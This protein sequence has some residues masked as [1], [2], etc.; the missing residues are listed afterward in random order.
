MLDARRLAIPTLLAT[1]AALAACGTPAPNASLEQ[2]RSSYAAAS[3]DPAVIRGANSEL[4]T[5]R[6]MLDNANSSYAAGD[7]AAEVTHRAYLASQQVQVAR[8]TA[9]ATDAVQHYREA[10]AQQA[11]TMADL[12]ARQTPK[13]L[14]MTLGSLLFQTGKAELAPGAQG[15]ID[16]LATFLRQN[17]GRSVEIQGYTDNTGSESANM[18]LSR[19]RADTV[20]AALIARGVGASRIET[21]GLGEAEPVADNSTPEGRQMNRRVEVVMANAPPTASGGS[22]PPISGS[23]P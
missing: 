23:K 1:A 8:E 4:Q 20:R 11:Q 12:K 5:A 18:A 15:S 22:T 21:Q 14:V 10:Q 7:D 17:P 9:A 3:Q 13:G 6:S 19:H 2:A 16:E